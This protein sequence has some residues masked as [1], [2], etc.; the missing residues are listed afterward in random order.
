MEIVNLR[1]SG[2][3]SVMARFDIAL[4]PEVTLL[5]WALK[6]TGS[7][8]R[9]F[10]PSPR[11]GNPS[12]RVSPQLMAEIT[13]SAIHRYEEGDARNDHTAA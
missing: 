4:S 13:G 1:P 11:H 2:A 3:G 7:G 6:R 5:D 10:P 8:L 12:A 9:V